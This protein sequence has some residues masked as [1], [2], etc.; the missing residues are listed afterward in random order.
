MEDPA[1]HALVVKALIDGLGGCVEWDEK[2][3]RLV[4]EQYALNPGHIRRETIRYVRAMGGGVVE[5]RNE[6]R[7]H[8]ADLY[9]FY[10]MVILPYAGFRDGLFVEMRLTGEDDPEFPEVTLVRAHPEIKI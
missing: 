5:Q 2:E 8:W 3:A 10:Y 1:E 7:H 4:I 6:R 9:R